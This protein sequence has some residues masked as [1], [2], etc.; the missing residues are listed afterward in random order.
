MLF[1]DREFISF[2]RTA[3]LVV[4]L[5]VIVAVFGSWATRPTMH[6]QAPQTIVQTVA[7]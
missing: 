3:L 2:Y 7:L 5:F 6:A 4:L 1:S